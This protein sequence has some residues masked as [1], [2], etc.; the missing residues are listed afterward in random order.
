MHSGPLAK[1]LFCALLSARK[2][3]LR[4]SLYAELGCINRR[5]ELLVGMRSQIE[6]IREEKTLFNIIYE[7]HTRYDLENDPLVCYGDRSSF[8]N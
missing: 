2:Q 5:H 8:V 3:V 1:E 7:R 6:A 4:C